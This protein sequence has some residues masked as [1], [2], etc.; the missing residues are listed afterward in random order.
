MSKPFW[1]LPKDM[2]VM[3]KKIAKNAL[4]VRREAAIMFVREAAFGTPAD[5]G[6]ARSNWRASLGPVR[7]I[8]G[9]YAP[10][11]KL[12]M[13]ESANANGA[14]SE[15]IMAM[16]RVTKNEQAIY[17]SNSAPYIGLLENGRSPQNS[18]FIAAAQMK[19]DAW[20]AKQKMLKGV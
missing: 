2:E 20:L 16:T 18:G 9:P 7:K 6:K 11:R 5:T 13:S 8:L 19:V 12:G 4:I 1:K 15:A 3:S 17:V 10:G 14:I